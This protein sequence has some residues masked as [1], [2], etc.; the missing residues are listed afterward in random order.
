VVTAHRRE[1]FGEGF[2]R[3]CTALSRLAS[4][5]DVQI[6]FPVHPNPNV[7]EPVN[8]HLTGRRS[9]HLIDPL[10]YVPF[11]DLMRRAHILIT[12][13]GGVQEEGPSLGKPILVMREKTERP[14]A[15][16]AGTVKLVGT[17]TDSI[18]GEAAR[19]LDDDDEY[20]RMSRVHNPYGDGQASERIGRHI[21]EYFARHRV[22]TG[23]V[24]V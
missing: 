4:R 7:R 13:S 15:V 10:E 12:D 1:S 11:V 18:E 5:P 22:E 17:D 14:E 8:R 23:V 21:A 20:G 9:V 16:R 19:L 2:D 6:V 24:Q 3:I